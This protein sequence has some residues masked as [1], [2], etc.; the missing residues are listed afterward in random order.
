MQALAYY[1]EL[2]QYESVYTT[3]IEP[4]FSSNFP[5]PTTSKPFHD[6]P[7]ESNTQ[8]E[9]PIADVETSELGG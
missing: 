5:T 8:S 6:P 9:L 1:I 3:T 7:V 2:L 4:P